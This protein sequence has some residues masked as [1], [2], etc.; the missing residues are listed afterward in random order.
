MYAH[1]GNRVSNGR[2]RNCLHHR[3]PEPD[4][5][6][7]SQDDRWA[8]LVSYR[9]PLSKPDMGSDERS[10]LMDAFDTGSLDAGGPQVEGFEADMASYLTH[11]VHPVALSSSAAA[12]HLAMLLADVGRGDEVLCPTLSPR[13]T[14]DA[15]TAVGAVPAFVDVEP[16]TWTIDPDRAV[17]ELH[18]RRSAA[19]VTLDLLGQCAD[20]RPIVH[21]AREL[22]VPVIED[23]SHTLGATHESQPAGTLGIYGIFSTPSR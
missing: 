18:A 2:F 11:Q 8:T 22:D 21:A 5:G 12:L 1:L 17:A 20:H 23:A 4:P 3:T 15:I 16:D 9:I 13:A 7:W 6:R 14:I 10:L 19:V